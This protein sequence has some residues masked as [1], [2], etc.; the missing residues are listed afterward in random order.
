MTELGV[1]GHDDS[2]NDT[3]RGFTDYVPLLS[4][5]MVY[6]RNHSR[7]I[8]QASISSTL[9]CTEL[10]ASYLCRRP[11]SHKYPS[12]PQLLPAILLLRPPATWSK[13]PKRE[14]KGQ[15]K[16]QQ[17]NDGHEVPLDAGEVL[18]SFTFMPKNP[19]RKVRGR[20]I[21]VIQERR[22]SEA[23]SSRDCRASRIATDLYI[24]E[25][26]CQYCHHSLERRCK[27]DS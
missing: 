15:H 7:R 17:R 18:K 9:N 21:K 25:F 19:E 24:C 20:K 4:H 26:V 8:I 6:L 11:L 13:A 14:P 27:R 22:Q 16:Y 5:L 1:L 12:L 23:F 2:V 3:D 10:S